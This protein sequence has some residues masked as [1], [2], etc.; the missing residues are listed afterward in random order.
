MKAALFQ[1]PNKIEV[2]EIEKPKIQKGEALIKISYAGICG[3]DLHIFK[4]KHPR[5]QA[6]PGNGS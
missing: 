3:T 2:K 4:G 1:G 5:A 6:P